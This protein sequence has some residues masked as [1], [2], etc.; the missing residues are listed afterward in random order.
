MIGAGSLA[1]FPHYAT[2]FQNPPAVIDLSAKQTQLLAHLSC[3]NI[4]TNAEVF[5]SMLAS[6]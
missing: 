3:W 4:I 1:N 6:G 2:F 5:H